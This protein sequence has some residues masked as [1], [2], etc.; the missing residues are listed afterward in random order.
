MQLLHMR[1]HCFDTNLV[2]IVRV[3]HS[4]SN[5][6][7]CV[8]TP[9]GNAAAHHL[10][11][12]F[13][14]GRRSVGRCVETGQFPQSVCCDVTECFLCLLT[15][16]ATSPTAHSSFVFVTRISVRHF[17]L[18]SLTLQLLCRNSYGRF[19]DI[20][21]CMK[22]TPPAAVSAVLWSDVGQLCIRPWGYYTG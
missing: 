17:W 4:N 5:H 14:T 13:V 8:L 9:D 15:S 7:V 18:S 12:T 22:A 10:L 21:F 20:V 6:A 2:F 11:G 3:V 16:R 19:P 1:V